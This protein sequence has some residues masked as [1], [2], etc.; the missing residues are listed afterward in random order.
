MRKSASFLAALIAS[1]ALTGCY[2][3][4]YPAGLQNWGPD[5]IHRGWRMGSNSGLEQRRAGEENAKYQKSL[6]TMR[7]ADMKPAEVA[8][9][10]ALVT[11]AVL[12][13]QDDIKNE[14]KVL[15]DDNP[16]SYRI[17]AAFGPIEKDMLWP[18]LANAIEMGSPNAAVALTETG[19]PWN[20]GRMAL[21]VQRTDVPDATVTTV[22]KAA[23][24][25]DAPEATEEEEATPKRRRS[26]SG[27]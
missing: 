16:R 15:G 25:P 3:Q 21:Y 24:A 7:F 4:Q 10:A 2:N 27:R 8:R 23:A 14:R 18:I 26:R 5:P 1:S 17:S 19:L 6:V 9:F 20:I 11:G 12:V 13:N 22:P